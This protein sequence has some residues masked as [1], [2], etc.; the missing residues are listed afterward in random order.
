MVGYDLWNG[1]DEIVEVDGRVVGVD[2]SQV[3]LWLASNN[4]LQSTI[5]SQPQ[6][7]YKSVSTTR[8]RYLIFIFTD[9]R[10][11]SLGGVIIYPLLENSMLKQRLI[12]HR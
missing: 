2:G 1:D 9:V 6:I 5:I 7:F 8:R 3:E 4:Q 12:R 11:V 10:L